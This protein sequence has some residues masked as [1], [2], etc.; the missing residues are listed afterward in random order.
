MANSAKKLLRIFLIRHA[1]PQVER[2]GLFSHK[3]ATKYIQE[4]DIAEVD[5][6]LPFEDAD[7]LHQV[8]RVFC[9]TLHRSRKTAR[10]LFGQ[11]TEYVE[12]ANFREFER[13]IFKLPY[14]K[15]P[16]NLWLV[17][18]R[19]L[20]LLGFNSK[21]IETF[22]EA[23]KRAKQAA[24]VLIKEAQQEGVAVL[25]AHGLLNKYLE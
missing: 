11:Q 10:A 15:L 19:L 14:L 18:A 7:V 23:R 24:Q 21:G 5:A 12:D 1:R 17:K 4:Y 22:K 8:K 25:V 9:S 16:I 2:T 6:A 13:R 20:W 3:Q